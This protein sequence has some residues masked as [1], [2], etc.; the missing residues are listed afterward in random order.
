MTLVALALSLAL[1]ANVVRGVDPFAFANCSWR[2][3]AAPFVCAATQFVNGLRPLP[4]HSTVTVGTQ[5]CLVAWLAVQIG[6]RHGAGL[7][8]GIVALFCGA[9][10]NTIPIIRYGAMPVSTRALVAIGSSAE[11]NVARGQLGK[12]VLMNNFGAVG[13]LGDILPIPYPIVRSVISFG[14]IAMA[15]GIVSLV[16]NRRGTERK[17]PIAV[18]CPGLKQENNSWSRPKR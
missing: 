5:L 9:L 18:G 12:H 6:H 4:F 15:A 1:L 3:P 17:K 14:D 16:L 8:D 13:W 7:T 11:R 10:L 2:W